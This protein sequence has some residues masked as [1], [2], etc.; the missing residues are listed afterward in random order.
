MTD[1]GI[2]IREENIPC[3]FTAFHRVDARKTHAI[4][5]TGLGLSI[6]KQL[7]DR[8]GGSVSVTSEYGKGSTFRIEL[9]QKIVDPAP[10]G[11]LETKTG[12]QRAAA[13]HMSAFTAPSLRV[14]AVD[15]TPMNLM[16]VKKLL[17][18]TEAAVDTAASGAEA[19][20]KTAETQYH[21]ILMDHQMPEMDG[22]ECLHRIRTQDNGK[23]RDSKVVCLTANVGSEMEALY[24]Q[25]GFDGYLVKPVRGAT[26][27]NELARL[28]P[29][30][31]EAL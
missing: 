16:V 23:C 8:M 15:D 6:V 2:G 7:L 25:A 1:T 31:E 5:G 18:D 21:V 26:L 27:E 22:I 14:L 4:E 11:P 10:I 13:A 20:V 9:P 28:V 17:R 30:A 19:L 24:R 12:A 29:T 3:L